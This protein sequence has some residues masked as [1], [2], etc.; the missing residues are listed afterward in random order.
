METISEPL[1]DRCEVIRL[2]GKGLLDVKS[3]SYLS[4]G[5]TY[6]EKI[7]IARKFLLPKQ[8]EANGLSVDRLTI[9]DDAY[10]HIASYYTREAGVRSLERAIGSVAR[11]KAVEWS[12]SAHQGEAKSTSQ[13]NPAVDVADLEPILGVP[14]WDPQERER[15]ERKG[16]VYG[17]VVSGQGEGGVLPVESIMTS[18]SGKLRLTGSLGEVRIC[19][20]LAFVT[21]IV[22]VIRESGEIALSWVKA[23][24]YTL[25]ITSSET[26]DPLK[27]PHPIDIHLHLPSGAVKK[28]GPSAGTALV[29]AF[30]SLLTGLTVPKYIAMTGETTLRGRITAVGGIKEKVTKPLLLFD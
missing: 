9:T 15:E 6:D 30:V 4:I 17:L 7:Q 25:G 19:K 11:W 8:L 1:L 21:H 22:Q 28:D 12:N 13:Y 10:E 3:L 26:Q 18:G 16:L 5:Y 27:E 2:S 23:H 20:S 29:C 14:R 24:A